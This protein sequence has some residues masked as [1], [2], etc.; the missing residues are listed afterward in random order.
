MYLFLS[1][2]AKQ[3]LKV[4]DTDV[5]YLQV[6]LVVSKCLHFPAVSLVQN[7]KVKWNCYLFK[8]VSLN[9][10]YSMFFTLPLPYLHAVCIC[11]CS[12]QYNLYSSCKDL[13]VS[14]EKYWCELPCL[15][16]L[17]LQPTIFWSVS[18][19]LCSYL[20]WFSISDQ[21][22]KG[23]FPHPLTHSTPSPTPHLS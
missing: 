13:F 23:A 5:T 14:L 20:L 4:L 6:I 18:F 21:W 11:N 15:R 19:Q 2:C 8:R 10:P 22:Q 17:A 1:L 16:I 12:F 9:P 3:L 7:N